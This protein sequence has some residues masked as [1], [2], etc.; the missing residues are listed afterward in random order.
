MKPLWLLNHCEIECL[1][2]GNTLLIRNNKLRMIVKWS[3]YMEHK[4]PPAVGRTTDDDEAADSFLPRAHRI[5]LLRPDACMR[6]CVSPQ[7]ATPW[8]GEAGDLPASCRRAMSDEP[9]HAWCSCS[10]ANR[11]PHACSH[12]QLTVHY[13]WIIY[14]VRR[15]IHPS[16]GIK[17]WTEART[18][19]RQDRLSLLW[20]GGH[21]FSICLWA[22]FRPKSG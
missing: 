19:G 14:E 2:K 9:M 17:I 16:S 18:T 12:G 6:A 3:I 7:R 1:D 21:R 13:T 8:Q 15:R 22:N 20:R 5:F 4:G 11:R 10:C